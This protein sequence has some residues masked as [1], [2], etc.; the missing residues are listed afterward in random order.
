[1]GRNQKATEQAQARNKRIF[2]ERWSAKLPS[3]VHLATE[4]ELARGKLRSQ[5]ILPADTLTRTWPLSQRMR[6]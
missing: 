5:A 3:L 2:L 6:R 1:M 4:N